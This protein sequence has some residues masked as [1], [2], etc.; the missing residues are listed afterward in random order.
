MTSNSTGSFSSSESTDQPSPGGRRQSSSGSS[1]ESSGTSDDMLIGEEFQEFQEV[2]CSCS[3]NHTC[4]L[5]GKYS[6]CNNLNCLSVSIYPSFISLNSYVLLPL[7][8]LLASMNEAA[9]LVEAELEKSFGG[10][11]PDELADE[12]GPYQ[13]QS[14]ICRVVTR[15]ID[16]QPPSP[17]VF[18]NK[19]LAARGYDSSHIQSINYRNKHP[20]IKQMADYDA[21][22]VTA[23]RSSDLQTLKRFYAEGRSMSACNKFSESI[24]HMACRR[25]EFDMVDFIVRHG[26]DICIIDDYG[27][28]PL[29][30]ACW[31]L[32]P[33]FD[34]VTL[35][36]DRHIDLIR[37]ADVR[38]ASPLK[39]VPPD[40]W[41]Q[42]CAYF[43]HQKDKYWPVV[44]D[45]VKTT[46][47]GGNLSRTQSF[48]VETEHLNIGDMNSM[49]QRQPVTAQ[50]S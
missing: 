34:I 1:A 19:L 37:M 7:L 5:C 14:R 42:W 33:R 36:L 26:G 21:A 35:L 49:S 28:T 50:E 32:S 38:G 27:R 48:A 12:R 45:G 15:W 29:H 20:S 30:D 31:R 39:Y 6:N 44:N 22:M 11:L 43:H 10:P 41:L 16:A 46:T 40:M 17:E 47:D 2:M 13:I 4:A 8:L 24:V 3:S 18:L 9:A 25:S 23:V